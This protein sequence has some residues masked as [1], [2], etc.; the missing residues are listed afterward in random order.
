[1]INSKVTSSKVTVCAPTSIA[2]RYKFCRC[3]CRKTARAETILAQPSMIA[4]ILGEYSLPRKRTRHEKPPQQLEQLGIMEPHHT[5]IEA[6][7]FE[8]SIVHGTFI[9]E[10]MHVKKH[11]VKSDACCPDISWEGIALSSWQYRH[12]WREKKQ[13]CQIYLRAPRCCSR[14]WHFQNL[15]ACTCAHPLK[16]HSQA[17]HPDEGHLFPSRMRAR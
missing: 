15:P 2:V 8:K 7:H 10:R 13:A 14:R 4:C 11:H 5:R 12:F 17:S 3:V 9:Y 6:T 16:A 1:M